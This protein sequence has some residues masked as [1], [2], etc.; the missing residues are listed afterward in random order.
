MSLNQ[1]L[2]CEVMKFGAA[3]KSPELLKLGTADFEIENYSEPGN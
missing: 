3:T 2:N 1:D